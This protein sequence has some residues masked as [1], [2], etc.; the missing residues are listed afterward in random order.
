MLKGKW[1]KKSNFWRYHILWSHGCINFFASSGQGVKPL[2]NNIIIFKQNESHVYTWAWSPDISCATAAGIH[3]YLCPWSVTRRTML[4]FGYV[5]AFYLLALFCTWQHL[6]PN[7]PLTHHWDETTGFTDFHSPCFG[8][9]IGISIW[10]NL[11]RFPL[12]KYL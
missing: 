8:Y 6:H 12:L 2:M 11:I 7:P 5:A 10:S 9:L 4:W 1:I 3:S